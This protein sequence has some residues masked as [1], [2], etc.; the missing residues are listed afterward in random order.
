MVILNICRRKIVNRKKRFIDEQYMKLV[1]FFINFIFFIGFNFIV[2]SCMWY[3]QF[4]K[5]L[6]DLFDR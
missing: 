5:V 1:K 3:I 4:V 6:V 2:Y